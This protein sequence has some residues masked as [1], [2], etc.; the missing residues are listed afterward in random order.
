MFNLKPRI[1]RNSL[2][3]NLQVFPC[4]PDVRRL[5]QDP[6]RFFFGSPPAWEWFFTWSSRLWE[7]TKTHRPAPEWPSLI[8]PPRHGCVRASID[9]CGSNKLK[10]HEIGDTY[11]YIY[12]VWIYL[13]I[14]S[15]SLSLN[16]ISHV[17]GR[18]SCSTLTS[19][20]NLDKNHGWPGM[21]PPSS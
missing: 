8:R 2:K 16:A 13:F 15:L 19:S 10:H 21:K 20:L 6:L 3:F 17:T 4:F 11:L 1:P 12:Y 14:I 18:G 9:D 7:D 5:F